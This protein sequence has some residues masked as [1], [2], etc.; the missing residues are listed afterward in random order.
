MRYWWTYLKGGSEAPDFCLWYGSVE[1]GLAVAH[2]LVVS[3]APTA[4]LSFEYLAE[5]NTSVTPILLNL[6]L[7]RR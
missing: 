5:K 1:L 2:V 3:T 4:V 6:L 7:A